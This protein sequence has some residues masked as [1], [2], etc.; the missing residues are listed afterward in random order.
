MSNEIFVLFL[1]GAPANLICVL[2]AVIGVW[3]R[4]PVALIAAGV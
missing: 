4:W 3:K 1:F 2:L